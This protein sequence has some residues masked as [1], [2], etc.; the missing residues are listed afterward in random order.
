[1]ACVVVVWESGDLGVVMLIRVDVSL[2]LFICYC[3]F[4][5]VLM[6]A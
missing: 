4:V 5:V 2:F 1:M 3:V 6:Y